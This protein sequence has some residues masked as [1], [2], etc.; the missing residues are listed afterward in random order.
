MDDGMEWKIIEWDEQRC[1]GGSWHIT[2]AN[3]TSIKPL[4]H[5]ERARV[6]LVPKALQLTT[7]QCASPSLSS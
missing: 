4:R 1:I 6:D 5:I 7:E 3:I 2:L